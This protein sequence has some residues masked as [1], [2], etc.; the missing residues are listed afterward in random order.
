MIYLLIILQLVTGMTLRL[1]SEDGTDV[2]DQL[3]AQIASSREVIAN[4]CAEDSLCADVFH[5]DEGVNMTVFTYLAESTIRRYGGNLN[6]PLMRAFCGGDTTLEDVQKMLWTNLLLAQ[7]SENQIICGI[8]ERLVVNHQSLSTKCECMEDQDCSGNE[9]QTTAIIIM[10]A[11]ILAA[12][13]IGT[14]VS[15]L[16]FRNGI[17]SL[18]KVLPGMTGSVLSTMVS[19]K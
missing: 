16:K 10:F 19:G 2:C 4:W 12:V 11:F 1:V 13:A 17:V 9:S 8:N 6:M 18:E 15:L 3:H 5:Q 7:R 14:C